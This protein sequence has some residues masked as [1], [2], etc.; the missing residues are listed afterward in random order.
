MTSVRGG[1]SQAGM[2]T[3]VG[4]PVAV[5]W[6]TSVTLTVDNVTARPDSPASTVNKV[7]FDLIPC[8]CVSKTF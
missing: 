6:A 4:P 1:V 5:R 3:S 7:N 8:V 2:V